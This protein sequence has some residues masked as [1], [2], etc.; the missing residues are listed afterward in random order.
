LYLG[1][2][3]TPGKLAKRAKSAVLIYLFKTFI[4]KF[5]VNRSPMMQEMKMVVNSIINPN[6]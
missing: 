1:G 6:Y 5:A 3:T 2:V 4:I